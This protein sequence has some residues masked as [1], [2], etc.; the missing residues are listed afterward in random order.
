M[1]FTAEQVLSASHSGLEKAVAKWINDRAGDYGGDPCG[2][3]RDLLY[4]GCASGI[5][6]GLVYYKDTTKFYADHKADIWELINE[7]AEECGAKNPFEFLAGLNHGGNLGSVDEV[8]NFL[9]W[10]GFEEAARTIAGRLTGE[11]E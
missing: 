8:E 4:G 11:C 6:G 2:P 10:F 1:T 3:L 5:V 9:A 7:R